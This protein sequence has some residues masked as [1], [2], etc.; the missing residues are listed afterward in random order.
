GEASRGKNGQRPSVAESLGSMD[1]GT[2]PEASG[3]VVAWL[4]ARGTFGHFI[5]GGL[6]RPGKT[7][8]TS[9]P[10]TGEHLASV[11]LGSA[12]DVAE[13]V[14]AARAAYPARSKLSGPE[15]ARWHYALARHVQKRERLL[16]RSEERRVGK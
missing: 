8:A 9:N 15:R 6:A 13:A 11:A 5:D 4:K 7:F 10:A 2:A 1:Y 14:K 12:S 3:E 16:A